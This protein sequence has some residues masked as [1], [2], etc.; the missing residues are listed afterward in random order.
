MKALKIILVLVIIVVVLIGAGLLYLNHYVQSPAFQDTVR[1]AARD[2][3]GA[4]VTIT[5]MKISLL[6][7]VTL[8]GIAIANP[9]GFT[10]NLL[11]ADSFVLRYRLLP[12]LSKRVAI[13]KLAIEKPV[14]A[15]VRDSTGAF[16]YEKLGGAKP[17]AQPTGGTTKS[18]GTSLDVDLSSLALSDGEVSMAGEGGKL[19]VKLAGLGLDTSVALAGN[20]MTG[21]GNARIGEI[22]VANSIFVR[23]V[24]A[25]VVMGANDI[26]L[27]PLS[28][29]LAGG[30]I[31]GG[32]TVQTAGAFKYVVDLTAK[33]SDV[34][35][36]LQEMGTKAVMT[37]KLQL[38]TKLEGTGGLPTMTGGGK[39]EIV[40]G[41][42]TGIPILNLLGTLLQ[43]PELQNLQ[44]SECVL[45]YTLANNVMQTPVIKL[46]SPYVQIAGSGAMELEKYTLNH[47]MT[48]AVAKSVLAKTPKE[49]QG[50]FKDRGDGYLTVDFKV[51]GPYDSPKT[52]LS[53]R[54]LKGAGEQ[55][56][57]KGLQKLLK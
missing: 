18:G 51:T 9:P 17:V 41:Q 23:E 8:R 30:T 24:K 13:E 49:I 15:L 29:Q 39:A 32:L 34:P 53:Q 11:T 33:D 56:L 6:E 10:G 31:G 22:N 28:G 14:V 55:L 25:P 45:E 1:Q 57:Q 40:N 37:G 50:A 21:R 42:L 44:F 19:L 43:V 20:K 27:S 46:T 16:N 35:K 38:S 54:L 47:T 26:Q 7:G 2:L 52:D 48:L 36:L 3:L 4:N 5:E 12:L